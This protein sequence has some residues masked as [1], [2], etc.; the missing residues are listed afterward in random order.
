MLEYKKG[1]EEECLWPRFHQDA[2]KACQAGTYQ[3]LNMG[4]VRA[5]DYRTRAGSK[6]NS[7]WLQVNVEGVLEKVEQRGRELISFL[8]KGLREKVYTNTDVI[9]VENCRKILDVRGQAL[10]VREH[11]PVRISS[12]H[13]K[14]FRDTALFF[15]PQLTTRLDLADLRLQWSQYNKVLE[16]LYS[17]QADMSSLKLIKLLIDPSEQY[18]RGIE[19]VLSIMV[20]AAVAKGGVESVVESMVSVMEAHSS[21][22][23]GITNQTR[24]EDEIMVA[25]NGEDT[26]HCDALVKEAMDTYWG[27]CKTD[28]NKGGHFIRRSENIQSYFVSEAVNSQVKKPVKLSIMTDS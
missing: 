20:R 15:E 26:Y 7:D 21:S 4:M 16:K 1:T 8:V 22:V 24:L 6:V 28:A 25:W 27:Q 2:M 18:F 11:G 23:R 10:K 19:G 12:L 17:K 13:F 3:G 9:L 5:E 14:N